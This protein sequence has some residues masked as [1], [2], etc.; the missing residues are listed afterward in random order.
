MEEVLADTSAKA[1][2]KKTFKSIQDKK[3]NK[4]KAYKVGKKE[5]KVEARKNKRIKAL[6]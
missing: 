4:I 3:N 1:Y 6:Y 2:T 5:K